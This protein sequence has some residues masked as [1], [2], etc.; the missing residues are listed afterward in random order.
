MPKDLK[1]L[2]I[3]ELKA[4]IFDLDSQRGYCIQLLQTK[5]EEA[6]RAMTPPLPKEEP[7]K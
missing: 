2:T 7:K 1:D 3:M 5:I 4:Y 6:N